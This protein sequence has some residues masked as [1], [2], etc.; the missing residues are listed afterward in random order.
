M[1]FFRVEGI[2]V[3]STQP[4]MRNKAYVRLQRKE[5]EI[6]SRHALAPETFAERKA[7]G[8]E[9]SEGRVRTVIHTRAFQPA[10]VIHGWIGEINSGKDSGGYQ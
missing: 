10:R 6:R 1:E 4:P 3:K 7:D 2:K 8:A 9:I 5:T